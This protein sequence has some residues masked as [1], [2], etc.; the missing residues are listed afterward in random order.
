MRNEFL[1]LRR[2]GLLYLLI[3]IPLVAV[4]AASIYY[5]NFAKDYSSL[6]EVQIQKYSSVADLQS[7]ETNLENQIGALQA[8]SSDYNTRI[9]ELERM[10][11]AYQYLE[12]NYVP[13]SSL[14]NSFEIDGIIKDKVFYNSWSD[15]ATMLI[16]VFSAIVLAGF[17]FNIDFL[18]KTSIPL[19]SSKK[20]PMKLL[21]NKFLTYL[22]V[23]SLVYIFLKVVSLFF[24]FDYGDVKQYVLLIG[25]NVRIMLSMNYMII[26]SITTLINTLFISTI[27]YIISLLNKNLFMALGLNFGIIIVFGFI[28]YKYIPNFSLFS[29]FYDVLNNTSSITNI[30]FLVI[31]KFLLI[32]ISGYI[33][34][35]VFN[36]KELV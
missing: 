16:T 25:N 3:L 36:N 28:F 11:A 29:S 13:Y 2:S 17:M 5:I 32:L 15:R 35:R 22:V 8:T 23:L 10:L 21:I 26:H 4:L 14:T 19:Y 18:Y 12:N 31:I 33:S 7:I 24:I 20:S 27:I 30:I 1:R 34:V 6:G 9:K